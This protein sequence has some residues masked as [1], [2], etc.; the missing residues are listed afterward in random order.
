MKD[1]RFLLDGPPTPAQLAGPLESIT[2]FVAEVC[3]D[4]E[5]SKNRL[6]G[7]ASVDELIVA[8]TDTH[9][10]LVDHGQ[11]MGQFVQIVQDWRQETP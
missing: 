10:T 11:T 4:L 2:H 7:V 1:A 9:K 5:A 3:R 8:A 6:S